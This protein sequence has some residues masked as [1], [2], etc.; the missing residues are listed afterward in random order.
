MTISVQGS[1]RNAEV[2]EFVTVLILQEDGMVHEF[3][4]RIRRS[5]VDAAHAEIALFKGHEKEDRASKR[6]TANMQAVVGNL[7]TQNGKLPLPKSVEVLLSNLSSSGV[8]LQAPQNSFSVN[9]IVEIK[10]NVNATITVMQAK[11]VRI[12]NLDAA[13]AEYGCE[14]VAA[15]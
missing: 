5:T 7:I 1:F 13:N 10:L 15:Y 14:L 8:S 4:G 3:R 12:R 2:G 9:S 6:Y 11:V